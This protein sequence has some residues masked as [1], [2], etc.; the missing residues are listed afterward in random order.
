MTPEAFVYAIQ[1][2]LDAYVAGAIGGQ[3]FIRRIDALMADELP[4]GLSNA[5]MALL[6]GFQDELALYVEDERQRSEHPAYFGPDAL[7]RK[8]LAMNERLEK[9]SGVDVNIR[10]EESGIM[11]AMKRTVLA[12]IV[13]LLTVPASAAFLGANSPLGE[14]FLNTGIEKV[15]GDVSQEVHP[16]SV[17]LG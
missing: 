17:G 4:D 12:L 6:N 2:A 15:A 16:V 3:D 1:A 7:S 10:P 14:S 8:A 13:L 5:L 11:V 9:C